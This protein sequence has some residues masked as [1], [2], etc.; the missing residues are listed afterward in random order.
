MTPSPRDIV[1]FSVA[2]CATA[3]IW[4][5]AKPQR[6]NTAAVSHAPAKLA[7]NQWSRLRLIDLLRQSENAV[8]DSE[9]WTV[10]KQISEIPG[11]KL[12]EALELTPLFKDHNLAFTAKILLIRWAE[13]DG[14]AAAHW[15]WLRFRDADGI[16]DRAFREIGPSWAAK[17][18]RGF[19]KWIIGH[20]QSKNHGDLTLQSALASDEPILEFG[21]LGRACTWLIHEDPRAAF[22]ILIARGGMSTDDSKLS[23]SLQT[24]GQIQ[25]AL[26]AFDHLDQIQPGH[27][28]GNEILAQQLISQWEKLDPE[29]FKRSPYARLGNSGKEYEQSVEPWDL[30]SS[31]ARADSLPPE[32]S[33]TAFAQA[34]QTWRQNHPSEQPDKTGWTTTRVRAWEDLEALQNN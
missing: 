15:A 29:T 2:C 18:P 22:E 12:A 16:W 13:T 9:R 10:A 33:R 7:A 32:E 14:N 20:Q 27:W 17:N 21:D 3:L 31:L 34:Y 23:E 19:A 26:L 6:T 1:L 4:R 25:Q 5:T 30:K 11:E 8:T 28:S 24:A